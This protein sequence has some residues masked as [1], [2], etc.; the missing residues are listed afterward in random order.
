MAIH[1]GF[2]SLE[3]RI[4]VDGKPAEEFEEPV[5]EGSGDDDDVI[6]IGNKKKDL[7]R[8]VEAKPSTTFAI[9]FDVGRG[10]KH[11]HNDLYFRYDIDGVIDYYKTIFLEEAPY[12]R[13][14]FTNGAYQNQI[15]RQDL[16]G[17]IRLWR[18]RNWSACS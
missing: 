12:E 14:Q 11:L 18:A 6:I 16:P 13:T 5:F 10:F 4:I 9:E 1:P 8:Y 3:V 2:P 17:R 7:E 15:G